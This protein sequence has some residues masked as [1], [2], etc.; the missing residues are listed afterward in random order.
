MKYL[1]SLAIGILVGAV[2]FVLGLYYNPFSAQTAVSPLA[3]T[4]DQ[5][6]DLSFSGVPNEGILYTDHGESVV[7]PYPDRV[8]ELWEPAVVKTSVWVTE[9][10]VG[11]GEATGIGVKFI[12][13]SEKTRL[14]NGEAL[15]NSVWH[16]YLPGQGT[17]LVDQTENY[18]SYIREVVIPARV[19]SGDNWLGA[20]HGVMTNG[21]GSLGTG[22]VTG[23]SGKFTNLESEAVES[24]SAR[25]YSSVTGPV[26][27]TRNLTIALS[28]AKAE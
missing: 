28:S 13:E 11:R 26:S 6:I 18:W 25:G 24:L 21:P 12:T 5:V 4:T 1:Y 20:F 16:V 19:S 27:M 14:I 15:A 17:F 2:L 7:S 8:S 22:R 9:F 23:G 3:V 10:Q